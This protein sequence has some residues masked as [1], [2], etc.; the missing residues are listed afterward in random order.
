MSRYKYNQY[1]KVQRKK[2]SESGAPRREVRYDF[3]VAGIVIARTRSYYDYVKRRETDRLRTKMAKLSDFSWDS[4]GLLE[5][6][7]A[8]ITV[9][10]SRYRTHDFSNYYSTRGTVTSGDVA[11]ILNSFANAEDFQLEFTT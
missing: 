4:G 9:G 3:I 1:L 8:K 5:I 7:N 2:I 10:S 6:F 11:R